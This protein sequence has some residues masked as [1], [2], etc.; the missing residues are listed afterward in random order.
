LST[1]KPNI[2]LDLETMG[3]KPTSAII[4][5]GACI[6]SSAGGIG[7]SFSSIVDLQSSMN[8][9]LTVDA[10]TISWWMMQ[11]WDARKRF[12]VN[13]LTPTLREALEAFQRW[14]PKGSI[15]WGN[16]SD[17]DNVILKNAYTMC[18]MPS[19]WPERND[20]CFRTMKNIFGD[21][22]KPKNSGVEH[23]AV[24][25]AKFQAEWILKIYQE[26]FAV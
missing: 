15:V 17:F 26:K 1:V 2:M 4:E 20:R 5:I 8:A 9:G 23:S 7:D 24:D 18:S 3:N 19:P 22:E 13:K 10:S 11:S 16:G 6:F 21:V 14:I 12:K 25:D